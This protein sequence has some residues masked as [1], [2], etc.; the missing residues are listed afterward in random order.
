MTNLKSKQ[1]VVI[2]NLSADTF[3]TEEIAMS[4]DEVGHMYSLNYRKQENTSKCQCVQQMSVCPANGSVSRSVHPANV[5]MSNKCHTGEFVNLNREKKCLVF[6]LY[7]AICTFQ[8]LQ[9]LQKEK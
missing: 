8:I 2:L 9:I 5:S 1:C 3:N 6:G 4:A 7:Q